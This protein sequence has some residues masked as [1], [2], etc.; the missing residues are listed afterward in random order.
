MSLVMTDVAVLHGRQW[1][2]WVLA[3][4]HEEGLL[5]RLSELR[6]VPLLMTW[7]GRMVRL[8]PGPDAAV[9]LFVVD[10][11]LPQARDLLPR[12]GEMWML[13][14]RG[15]AILWRHP[16]HPRGEEPRPRSG[17]P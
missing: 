8:H 17:R 14:G 12:I 4:G 15:S 13:D 6:G 7:D 16:V 11:L 5:V 9:P 3:L 2:G 10:G 1:D